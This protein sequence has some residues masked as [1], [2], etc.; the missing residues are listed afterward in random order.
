MIFSKASG[1]N[2]S[3]YGKSQE[4][5]KMMLEQAEEAFQKM[6]IIDKVFY[7]DE[8]KDFANKDTSETSLGNFLPTGEN[9]KYAESYMQQGYPKVIEPETWKNH[10]S[11]TQEMVEDAKIGKIKTRASAFMLSYNRTKE[12]FAAGI[13]NN[14]N[15]TTMNFMGK[16]FDLSLIHISKPTRLLSI[17]YAVF[18]LKK[19]K[20]VV[21]RPKESQEN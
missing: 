9:G 11:V 18:C 21:S 7:M 6:S 14:G 5:I 1:A 12:L 4:P 19:K 20:V 8:T 17:S 3:I 2:E 10:F 13:L 15:A 16:P